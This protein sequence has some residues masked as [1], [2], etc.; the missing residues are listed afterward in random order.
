ME[1]YQ[2][3]GLPYIPD[4]FST[5]E[6]AVGCGHAMRTTYQGKRATA[7]DYI[8]ADKKRS[9]VTITC[10]VTVDKVILEKGADGT[11]EAKG[12]EYLDNNG[13]KFK[14]FARKEVALAGGT[15]N[16][17]TMLLRSGIG[18]KA[19]LEKLGIPVK[20]D[21]PGVGKNLQV[22]LKVGFSSW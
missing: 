4:M 15:Y 11:L 16:S 7:A 5:G 21:L 9:N 1:S 13:N 6:A 17:P 20:V 3:K 12:V 22:K 2:S 8:I 18:P 14:A 10:D 19:D